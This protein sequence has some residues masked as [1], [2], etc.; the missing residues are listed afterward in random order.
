ME[1]GHRLPFRRRYLAMKATT[2]GCSTLIRSACIATAK[3][4]LDALDA[5][6]GEHLA[7]IARSL[8]VINF[9]VFSTS[10]QPSLSKFTLSRAP[11]RT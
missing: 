9:M 6:A 11:R 1:L 5:V 2:D 7:M 3:V 10:A 8:R 4:F